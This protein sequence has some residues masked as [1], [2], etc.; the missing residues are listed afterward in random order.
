MILDPL[1][2]DSLYTLGH[3]VISH[4]LTRVQNFND[5]A[6]IRIRNGDW[7]PTAT[8]KEWQ[9]REAIYF[10]EELSMRHDIQ[11]VYKA[12]DGWLDGCRG[13]DRYGKIL[14]SGH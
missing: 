7:R 5:H 2:D 3:W 6:S 14:K 12:V 4:G 9:I 10:L 1:S 8:E 13:P 11:E